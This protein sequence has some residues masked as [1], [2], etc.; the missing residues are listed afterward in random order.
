MPV[1]CTVFMHK[2]YLRG[3]R[4]SEKE[5][6][7]CLDINLLESLQFS[8]RNT[9]VL[10]RCLAKKVEAGNAS[11]LLLGHRGLRAAVMCRGRGV[12]ASTADPA[13][14]A[15]AP[16]GLSSLAKAPLGAAN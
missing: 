12:T 15:P 1:L 5:D 8:F 6:G 13:R 16:L 10:R 14:P 9:D 2:S 11:R 3:F 7:R 4:S